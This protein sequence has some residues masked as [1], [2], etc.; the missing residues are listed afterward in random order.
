MLQSGLSADDI[1]IR[2]MKGIKLDKLD[3]S[4]ITY[5][6]NCT[7]ERVIK[8]LLTTGED[9]LLEMAESGEDTSVECHFCD[10]VYKFTPDEI[11]CLI[12]NAK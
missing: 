5:K 11:R 4:E 3:E 7:R 10:K 2:A 1:A 8:A 6:C 12:N 9:T